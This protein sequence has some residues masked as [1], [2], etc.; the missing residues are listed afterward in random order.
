MRAGDL[1]VEDADK[2]SDQQAISLDQLKG[3]F[4]E[5]LGDAPVASPQDGDSHAGETARRHDDLSTADEAAEAC[6]TSPRSILEAMLFVGSSDNAPLE[7]KHVSSLMRG[8]KSSEIADLV[9]E[10]NEICAGHAAP[11]VIVSEG[12]GYRLTLREKHGRTRDK[13]FARARQAKLSQAAIE[14][15]SI[16]A[17][18]QPVTTDAVNRLRAAQSG[19]ILSQLTRRQL[20][21]VERFD[22]RPRVANYSTT[23]RFLSLF[24]LE[25]LSDLP[26]SEDIDRQ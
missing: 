12:A 1:N 19:A 3:A 20:L 8:V 15:L 11:Y 13:F 4:A 6:E 18:N 16:V 23:D 7:A 2:E 17:Y 21:R 9:S 10:L 14:V 24:G 22:D 25:S 26:R 5:M